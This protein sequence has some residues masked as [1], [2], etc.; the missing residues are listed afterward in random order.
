MGAEGTVVWRPKVAKPPPAQAA[1]EIHLEA[2]LSH[3]LGHFL[4]YQLPGLS[5]RAF[6]HVI[7]RNMGATSITDVQVDIQAVLRLRNDTDA[8]FPR[9]QVSLYGEDA[10]LL[11]PPKPFGLLDVNPDSPLAEAWLPPPAAEPLIPAVYP[12]RLETALPAHDETELSFAH[13]TRKPARIVHLCDSSAVP[14][15]SPAAGVPLRRL[16]LVQNTPAIGL[17]IPL[18]PGEADVHLGTSRN[19]PIQ[20]GHVR[21]TPYPG[22]LQM[23]MGRVP[24]VRA[25]RKAAEWLPQ[26]DHSRVADF[27]I[28]LMNDL[29]APARIHVLERLEVSG[30]WHLVRTSTP[31][32]EQQDA[33]L[34]DVVVPANSSKT[35]QYRL[36][37][38]AGSI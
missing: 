23:D 18:P 2:P 1:L 26:A 24:A 19:V 38:A 7:V 16:L 25:V 14:S 31:A 10:F 28:V 3:R 21:H 36:R 8:A 29:D 5:W 34:Y 4:I 33:L 35:I 13:V 12:F 11:P 30:Q 17:G 22:T 20:T 9:A 37:L 27:D 6:Y 15:P 32:T